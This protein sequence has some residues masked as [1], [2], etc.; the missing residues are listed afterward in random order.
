MEPGSLPDA[1]L[2]PSSEPYKLSKWDAG[3]SITLTA[4]EKYWGDPPA[5]QTVVIRFIAQD[6]QVQALQNGLVNIIEPQS[7][8]DLLN[9]AALT[10]RGNGHP[11]ACHFAATDLTVL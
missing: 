2:I 3:Q 4:N 9:Q 7:N 10:D 1:S 11:V 5:V 8:P 6:E